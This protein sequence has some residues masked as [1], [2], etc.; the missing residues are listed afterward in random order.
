MKKIPKSIENKI[1]NCAKY[2]AIANQENNEILEWLF[3][4]NYNEAMNDMLIDTCQYGN[5]PEGFIAFLNGEPDEYGRMI[6]DFIGRE[7]DNID[8]YA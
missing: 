5:D 7:V 3:K 8:D 6:D 4:N 1:R 2:Y